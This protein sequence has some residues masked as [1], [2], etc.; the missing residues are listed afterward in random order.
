M[1]HI[2]LGICLTTLIVSAQV[3]S[4]RVLPGS[5]LAPEVVTAID[6][7]FAE[8]NSGPG[9]VL[10]V[11]M[12]EQ[13]VFARG[14]GMANLEHDIPLETH[15]N[16]N[17]ASVSKRFTG[18]CVAIL[19]QE[20]K[21]SFDD[22]VSR[23]IP[24]LNKYPE[25]IRLKYL[26][27]NTSGLHEYYRLPRE[28]GLSWSAL[29]HFT[30]EECI[31][32]ALTPDTLR[33]KP[34]ERWDYNNVNFM[35]L[36]E[37]VSLVSG[38]SLASFAEKHIFEPLGMSHTRF[39][40]D[41]TQIIKFRALGYNHRTAESVPNYAESGI[42]IT[43]HGDYIQVTRNSPHYGGSG[44]YASVADLAKWCIALQNRTFRG[45]EFYDI[46]HRQGSF[47]HGRNNQA[48]G[49]YF[50]DFN[51]RTIVAWDGGDWGFSTE[52]MRFPQQQLAII[53][54]SNLG[55]GRASQH[56]RRVADILSDHGILK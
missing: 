22:D 4:T 30:N 35:L 18:A 49:L 7:H 8:F 51:G 2:L 56:A 34:G 39:N 16:F 40:D 10:G 5:E 47:P 19:I 52:M 44:L 50:G 9:Y 6:A 43:E 29:N 48:L 33:F 28:N 36:A 26:L 37:I 38:M 20:G 23:Y 31:R 25:T 3:K 55:T 42:K 46:L 11:V 15:T 14:Y 13:I 54:L 1:R 53:C 21:L 24:A 27:Y 45:S 12:G 32:V 17:L 41:V